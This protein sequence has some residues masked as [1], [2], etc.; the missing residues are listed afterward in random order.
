MNLLDSELQPVG[1]LVRGLLDLDRSFDEADALS[2]DRVVCDLPIELAA[3]EGAIETELVVL[4]SPPR[5][6]IITSVMPVFHRM[7]ITVV[8]HADD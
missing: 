8:Q 6:P 5:Q 3:R 1:R 2:I 4:V 7:R